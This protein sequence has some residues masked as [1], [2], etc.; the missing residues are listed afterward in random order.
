[1]P[2]FLT[3]Y[4]KLYET[5]IEYDV[6]IYVGEEPNIKEEHAHSY[7]LCARSQYFQ[8]A[9]SKIWAEKKD[10]KFIF[11]K[12]NISPQLFDIILRYCI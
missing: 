5:R 8:V 4:E 6:I 10:G 12:P 3:D 11:E 1:M 2:F 7:I 9:F